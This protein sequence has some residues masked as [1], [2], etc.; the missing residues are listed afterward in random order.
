MHREW[1]FEPFE[2]F[3]FELKSF[4]SQP[5][6]SGADVILSDFSEAS[7]FKWLGVFAVK[8]VVGDFVGD[9]N[10]VDCVK[11]VVNVCWDV[12]NWLQLVW[13]DFVQ[14]H[15]ESSKVVKMKLENTNDFLI[16]LKII[17]HCFWKDSPSHIIQNM[18]VTLKIESVT[19]G[20]KAC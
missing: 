11:E 3:Q 8:V 18:A 10:E 4:K 6:F 7:L 12:I 19:C 20:F 5:N 13:F 14:L 17:S 9:E 1:W 2:H 15:F 16:K